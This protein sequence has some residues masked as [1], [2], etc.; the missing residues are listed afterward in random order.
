LGDSGWIWFAGLDRRGNP[1]VSLYLFGGSDVPGGLFAYTAPR[2]RVPI[3]EVSTR[4]LSITDIHGTWLG[5]DDG[6]YLLDANDRLTKVS[7]VTGGTIAGGC[8]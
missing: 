2:V 7:D 6:I 3:S 8:N 1:L 5:G 4:Q